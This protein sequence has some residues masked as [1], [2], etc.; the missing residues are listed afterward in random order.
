M[1]L[2]IEITYRDG[3]KRLVISDQ[4]WRAATGPILMSEIYAGETYDA[5]QEKTGWSAPG[6]DDSDWKSVISLDDPQEHLVAPVSPPVRK[7]EEL[8]PIPQAS[9]FMPPEPSISRQMKTRTSATNSS[10][11][12]AQELA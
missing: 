9:S 4:N 10:T 2:Q 7:Q 1:L 5:R 6:Y 8:T 3:T 12:S 11:A